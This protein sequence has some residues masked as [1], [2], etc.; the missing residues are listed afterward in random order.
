MAPRLLI[1]I[2]ADYKLK[3]NF[4]VSFNMNNVLN[5]KYF[6]SGM[7]TGLVPQRGRWYMFSIGI[8]I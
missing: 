5:T 4:M 1:N 2:G 8:G 7:N 6:R 3:S